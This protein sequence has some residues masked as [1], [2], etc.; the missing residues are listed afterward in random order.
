MNYI[1]SELWEV[2]ILTG[3][4]ALHFVSHYRRRGEIE[5]LDMEV[6]VALTRKDEQIAG[7]EAM[8]EVVADGIRDYEEETF[9]RLL[10]LQAGIKRLA[11]GTIWRTKSGHYVGVRQMSDTHLNAILNFP[12]ARPEV[13][14]DVRAEI[15]R[16]EEDDTW[17]RR[18]GT[19]SLR[20]R[21]RDLEI[22][23]SVARREGDVLAVLEDMEDA[24]AQAE[25]VLARPG[26]FADG[27]S[28]PRRHWR[29]IMDGIKALRP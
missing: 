19:K 17:A 18:Q 28:V 8:I 22:A 14:E 3:L 23:R 15:A 26:S 9:Q 2:A 12:T 25:E 20:D 4:I 10:E 21:V 7:L 1:A 24:R 5:A 11:G 16:R 13:K 29:R 6:V 27:V